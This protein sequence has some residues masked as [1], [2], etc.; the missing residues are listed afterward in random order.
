MKGRVTEEGH[1]REQVHK[2]MGMLGGGR[3]E[4]ENTALPHG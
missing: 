1:T 4:E 2:G 3:G